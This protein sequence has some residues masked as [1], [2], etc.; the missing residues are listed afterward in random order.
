MLFVSSSHRQ[1]AKDCR[2]ESSRLGE[3]AVRA[4]RSHALRDEAPQKDGL[5]AP[6]TPVRRSEP[7]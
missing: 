5:S 7:H 1:P 2:S 4:Q 3:E 6:Q